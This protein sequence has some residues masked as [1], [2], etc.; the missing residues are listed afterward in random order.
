MFDSL[1]VEH[2]GHTLDVQT[3][4]FEC[5]LY[6]YR[7]GDW[8]CGA[9]PGVVAYFD[10]L[11]IDEEGQLVYGPK[12]A[13]V[14]AYT[15]LA[16]LA[17]GVFVDYAIRDGEMEPEA[18]AQALMQRRETWQDSARLLGFFVEQVR[19]KQQRL[20]NYAGVLRTA[21]M[22]IEH[23]QERRAGRRP[24]RDF[25]GSFHPEIKRLDDGE[26]PLEV[27]A[28]ILAHPESDRPLLNDPPPDPLADYRL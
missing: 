18:I 13:S 8:I 22:A 27:I 4:R 26:D 14:P 21:Q 6:N 17:H 12:E 1:R 7:V 28:S 2:N 9:P 11:R 10:I 25:W 24:E 20:L 15:L 5:L 23:V 19:L 3:K 16:V